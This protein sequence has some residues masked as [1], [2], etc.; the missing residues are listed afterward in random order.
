[1]PVPSSRFSMVKW[2]LDCVTESGEVAILYSDGGTNAGGDSR[3][4]LSLELAFAWNSLRTDKLVCER[5]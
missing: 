2:Y 3:A 1:V 5:C 4:D